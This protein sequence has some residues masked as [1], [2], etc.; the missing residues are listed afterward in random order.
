MNLKAEIQRHRQILL[1]FLLITISEFLIYWWVGA[2][3]IWY[4]GTLMH[5]AAMATFVV[6]LSDDRFQKCIG[7]ATASAACIATI[8]LCM[9]GVSSLPPGP[10]WWNAIGCFCAGM[11]SVTV[12]LFISTAIG[13]MV[14]ENTYQPLKA[15]PIG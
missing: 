14:Y 7:I 8:T 2:G 12:Y 5:H 1:P 15:N 6:G 13:A 3:F 9:G 11:L 10:A 4:T